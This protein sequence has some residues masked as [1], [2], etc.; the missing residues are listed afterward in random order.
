MIIGL[1]LM[2]RVCIANVIVMQVRK[3][4]NNE[5]LHFDFK[6]RVRLFK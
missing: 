3:L 6:F 2:F 4:Y 1:H 5:R